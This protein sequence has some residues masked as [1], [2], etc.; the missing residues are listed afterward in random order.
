VRQ[1]KVQDALAVRVKHGAIHHHERLGPAAGDGRKGTIE[2][3][4]ITHLD[5]LQSHPEG[6]GLCRDMPW[7]AVEDPVGRFNENRH[8]GERRH[9]FLQQL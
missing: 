6:P 3:P 1:R 4:D 5:A 7:H 2:C 9:G 8:L